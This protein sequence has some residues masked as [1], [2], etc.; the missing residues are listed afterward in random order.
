MLIQTYHL[1]FEMKQSRVKYSL[2][3]ISIAKKM[4]Y[5]NGIKG[6][7]IYMYNNKPTMQSYETHTQETQTSAVYRNIEN[8]TICKNPV[9]SSLVPLFSQ[10]NWIMSKNEE[11]EIVFKKRGGLNMYIEFFENRNNINVT[12]P[13]RNSVY[14]YRVVFNTYDEAYVYVETHVN[15][16]EYNDF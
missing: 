2:H 9:F 15:D 6:K 5:Y 1:H 10:H 14:Q 4:N 8:K 11:N 13:L 16:L 3:T 12:V 7:Y